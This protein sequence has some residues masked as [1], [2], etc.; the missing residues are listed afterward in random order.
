MNN[1]KSLSF[2]ISLYIG[3]RDYL[4]AKEDAD[5]MIKLLPKSIDINWLEDYAHLDYVWSE[6]ASKD[7]F[8]PISQWIQGNY[9]K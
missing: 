9:V 2:P 4:I 5:A 8:K 3:K 1:L 6:Y 7:I